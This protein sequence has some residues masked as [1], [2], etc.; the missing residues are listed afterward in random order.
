MYPYRLLIWPT[1]KAWKK[2]HAFSY[3]DV[4]AGVVHTIY[5]GHLENHD[6][7]FPSGFTS[8]EW[9]ITNN[10]TLCLVDRI[11]KSRQN[12][13]ASLK[14]E[15]SETQIILMDEASLLAIQA[16]VVKGNALPLG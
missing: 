4:V 14:P 11:D 7:Y 13:L 12:G 8:G 6:D 2:Y 5:F 1:Y 9:W 15:I 16:K 10:S 3:R